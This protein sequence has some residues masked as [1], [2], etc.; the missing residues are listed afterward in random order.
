[1]LTNEVDGPQ[2]LNVPCL[3]AARPNTAVQDSETYV[4]G[5]RYL[6]D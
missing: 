2:G 1:M 4:L 3:L 5:L 6:K